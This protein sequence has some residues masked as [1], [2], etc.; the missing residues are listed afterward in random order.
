M[1]F[2]NLFLSTIYFIHYNHT[3][4]TQYEI[5][6]LYALLTIMLPVDAWWFYSICKMKPV[7]KPGQREIEFKRNDFK[8]SCPHFLIVSPKNEQK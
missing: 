2:I 7:M 5:N 4:L 1:R 8:Q 3:R 6:N